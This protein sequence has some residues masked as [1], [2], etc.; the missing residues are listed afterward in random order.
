MNPW[1]I[2]VCANAGGTLSW[3]SS[4]VIAT[5]NYTIVDACRSSCVVRNRCGL[6]HLNMLMLHDSENCYSG[7]IER[8][9]R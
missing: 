1:L 3:A 6:E 8:G 5:A 9:V 4:I 7:R 2:P